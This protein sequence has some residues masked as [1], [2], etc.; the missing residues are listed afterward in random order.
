MVS[1]AAR[2][3]QQS[4]LSLDGRPERRATRDWV[5]RRLYEWI[6]SGELEPGQPL[7]EADLASAL[8]VSRQPIREAMRQLELDGLVTPAAGNGARAVAVFNRDHVVELYSIR[9]ALESVSFGAACVRISD[10]QLDELIQVQEQLESGLADGAVVTPGSYDPSLDF[11][12]HQVVAQASGMPQLNAFLVNI[13]LKTWALLNQLHLKGT[14]P[15]RD[16][17]ADSYADR[18]VLLDALS[19]RD[20]QRAS[21]A[22]QQHVQH[23]MNQLLGAIDSGRGSFKLPAAASDGRTSYF[24]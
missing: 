11:R 8:D 3:I 2:F 5:L 12:F 14:Y 9:A 19:S 23:R 10:A 1:V 18:R 24:I 13:W 4:P 21:L 20:P 16:E 6:F 15:S 17:I 22:A 7:S